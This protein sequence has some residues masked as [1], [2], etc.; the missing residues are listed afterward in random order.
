MNDVQEQ[1]REALMSLQRLKDQA[2]QQRLET[3]TLLQGLSAILQPKGPDETFEDM[4][5]VFRR[6]IDF[7][8]A[9]MLAQDPEQPGA[10]R[11]VAATDERFADVQWWPR[12]LFKRVMRGKG[13]TT[14]SIKELPE[15]QLQPHHI[16]ERVGSA[17]YAPVPT[18]AGHTALFV[19]IHR[20]SGY[21]T[22]AHVSLVSRFALVAGQ[23]LAN[24]EAHRLRAQPG[25]AP[26]RLQAPIQRLEAEV[27][28]LSSGEGA[29]DVKALKR[30]IDDLKAALGAG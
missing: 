29:L 7:E 24:V 16:R 22:R 18:N 3:E 25:E 23:A 15:W 21:F 8:E 2:D 17:L 20:A 26:A 27:A 12:R 13:T 5:L 30:S 10:L 9:F 6:I 28:R 4:F 19:M 11:C 1:L 14:Y